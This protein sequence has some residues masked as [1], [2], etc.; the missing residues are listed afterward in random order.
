ML[1][2]L[3]LYL[4]D[5]CHSWLLQPDGSYIKSEPAEGEERIHAQ[6]VLLTRLAI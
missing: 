2:E 5:N 6:Q 4:S 3:E 1:E